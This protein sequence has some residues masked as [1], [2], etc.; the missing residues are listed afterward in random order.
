MEEG[1]VAN[2]RRLPGRSEERYK[3]SKVVT[4]RAEVQT[5]VFQITRQRPANLI[6][7]FC[8]KYI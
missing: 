2:V 4:F 1:V 7:T 5:Q 8:K 3:N 6:T